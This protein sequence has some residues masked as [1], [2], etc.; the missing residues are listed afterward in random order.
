MLD[1]FG[2]ALEW[3]WSKL[4]A[5]PLT[6]Q[7][8]ERMVEGT[9]TQAGGRS[10]VDLERLRDDYL[11]AVMHALRGTRLGAGEIIARRE[12]RI[13]DRAAPDR[14]SQDSSVPA[15]LTLYQCR[16][17]PEW[18]DYNRHMTESAYLLAFGWAS[19]ALFR[20]IGIDDSYRTAGHSFYTVESHLR[21]KREVSIGDPLG[22]TTQVLDV[23]EK[24][25]HIFQV[26]THR[27]TSDVVCTNEQMLV[28]VDTDRDRSS[29]ILAHPLAALMAI[30]ESHQ[31]LP[32]PQEAVLS[33]AQV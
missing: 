11:I 28:H 31:V 13:L 16:V 8:V 1:Q 21:Y 12:E 22:F 32:H 23:D 24:R 6:D 14:W 18:T 29:S 3:P 20:Y 7:L 30:H 15:P 5:P 2:P 26:M 19:D 10:V 25:L 27:D 9:S 4:V 33:M 17:V